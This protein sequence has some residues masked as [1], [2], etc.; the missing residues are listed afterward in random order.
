M[1]VTE[2]RGRVDGSAEVP[3]LRSA[4]VEAGLPGSADRLSRL[5][6]PGPFALVVLFISP[7]ADMAALTAG[8]GCA[9]GMAPV[10]GCTTAG[11]IAPEGYAEGQIVAVALPVANFAV[12]TLLIPDLGDLDPQALI[13]QL[14]RVRQG[15]IA[16]RPDW[17]DEFA[18]L[19]VDGLS[20]REDE[21]T[22]ALA[23]GLG[24][25]P[26]FG[27]S[28]G[29]GTRFKETFVLH[30]GVALRNAAV[31]AHGAQRLPG[32]GLQPRSPGADRRRAWW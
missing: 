5:L 23:S 6:G 21:L 18:F 31:L 3:L 11:E 1:G 19:M 13:G 17:D 4:S 14:I 20:I 16:A 24:P 22:A 10:I 9:F 32:Q 30:E 15:L 25:V 8:L 2:V 27:G 26:L 12:E 29:D 7:E 28:A